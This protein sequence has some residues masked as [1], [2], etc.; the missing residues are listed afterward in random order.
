MRGEDI[1]EARLVADEVQQKVDGE[2]TLPPL[3]AIL[4]EGSPSMATTQELGVTETPE[5]KRQVEPQDRVQ[6]DVVLALVLIFDDFLFTLP[7]RRSQ[8]KSPL[9]STASGWF[10]RA[11]NIF[12]MLVSPFFKARV[13]CLCGFPLF[14][15]KFPHACLRCGSEI[16]V[17][18]TEM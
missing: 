9:L 3:V 8:L 10:P 6:L 16:F 4:P 2:L 12:F 18:V 15:H 13:A 17:H 5:T 14:H 11:A 7:S 1:G